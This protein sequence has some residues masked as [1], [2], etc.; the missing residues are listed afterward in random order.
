MNTT[1]KERVLVYSQNPSE[2]KYQKAFNG[3]N[4]DISAVDLVVSKGYQ[5]RAK[6]QAWVQNVTESMRVHNQSVKV[7]DAFSTV[8]QK[9][10]RTVTGTIGYN[11]NCFQ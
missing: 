9:H 11:N 10:I 2:D 3:P 5:D 1:T 6:I 7:M 4:R 8:K